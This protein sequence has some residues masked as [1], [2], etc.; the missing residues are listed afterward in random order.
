VENLIK[1]SGKLPL[2]VELNGSLEDIYIFTR[3][4]LKI[5]VSGNRFPLVVMLNKPRV[6]TP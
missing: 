2:A 4:W 1:K 5:A 6:V 3:G